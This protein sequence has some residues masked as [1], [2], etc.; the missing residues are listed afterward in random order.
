MR[1][2]RPSEDKYR[3]REGYHRRPAVA[4]IPQMK[5]TDH[6]V[7]QGQWLRDM[8][9]I[10]AMQGRVLMDEKYRYWAFCLY[11]KQFLEAEMEHN[12]AFA[13]ALV[14]TREPDCTD[15]KAV[16]RDLA[17]FYYWYK[18]VWLPNHLTRG[19][20]LTIYIEKIKKQFAVANK[21]RY[22]KEHK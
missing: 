18:Y 12:L 10:D 1:A 11:N 22:D 15:T 16:R 7:R 8:D 5:V 13:T 4:D 9:V 2:I 3:A 14:A 6:A 20:R 17:G 19:R 21:E